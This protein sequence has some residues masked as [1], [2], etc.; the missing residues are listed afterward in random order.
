MA[1]VGIASFIL[2]VWVGSF[3]GGTGV[4]G[5]AGVSFGSSSSGSFAGSSGAGGSLDTVETGSSLEEVS[6]S[7][8]LFVTLDDTTEET[9]LVTLLDVVGLGV[10]EEVGLDVVEEVGLGVVEEVG[11]VAVEVGV[12]AVDVGA[13][14]VEVGAVAV[15]VGAITVE[16]GAVAVEVGAVAV[17]AGAG[18]L[19]VGAGSEV[20]AEVVWDS[21]GGAV[22]ADS[23]NAAKPSVHIAVIA[24]N[25]IAAKRLFF[26]SNSYHNDFST[27]LIYYHYI[28]KAEFCQAVCGKSLKIKKKSP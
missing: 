8:E 22:T 26:I 19:V 17:E 9:V 18:S 12:V 28:A 1:M 11:V 13:V 21:A 4:T 16:V 14:A 23:A 10:V 24:E 6:D 3:E 20:A 2:S 27:K 15:E 25:I 5:A 7:V